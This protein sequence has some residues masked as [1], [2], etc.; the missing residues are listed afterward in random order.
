MTITDQPS[1]LPLIQHNCKR[2]LVAASISALSS[3]ASAGPATRF[4]TICELQWGDT[5]SAVH[6]AG[7]DVVIGADLLY[8]YSA[9]QPLLD[10]LLAIC[11]HSLPRLTRILLTYPKARTFTPAFFKLAFKW[12]SIESVPDSELCMDDY[13]APA[14]SSAAAA[15]A[16]TQ[17]S[18][19]QYPEGSTDVTAVFMTLKPDVIASFALKAPASA[20]STSAPSPA[21]ATT[22]PQ[23]KPAQLSAASSSAPKF[24]VL[25]VG[26]VC[27]DVV[28]VCKE[29]PKEDDSV[30][31]VKH[32]RARG[33]TSRSAE[34]VGRTDLTFVSVC[35]KC[36]QHALRAFAVQ[37]LSMYAVWVVGCGECGRKDS[38]REGRAQ[39]VRCG[40]SVL[41][42]FRALYALLPLLCIVFPVFFLTL[43]D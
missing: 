12:F 41:S 25:A 21:A 26:V 20:A 28:N 3:A 33:G 35:R 19:N 13:A 7:Y 16:Q 37:R 38:V 5:S 11:R 29:Y 14:A 22:A 27:L 9:L 18:S 17:T 4:P 36:R 10:S 8:S 23:P 42:V 24:L 40:R 2:N 30:Q 6:T 43:T 32:Y 34:G 39:A 1:L 15:A 31:A